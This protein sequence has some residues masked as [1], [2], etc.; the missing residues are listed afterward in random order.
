MYYACVK[1]QE[2]WSI[3]DS[4]EKYEM[5]LLR[6]LAFDLDCIL[7]HQYVLHILREVEA[8]EALAAV[9][10]N[11]LND[12]L[13][14]TLSL[15]YDPYKLAVGAIYLAGELTGDRIVSFDEWWE[16]FDCHRIE[17]DRICNALIDMYEQLASTPGPMSSSQYISTEA[18]PGPGA[19]TVT[20][21]SNGSASTATAIATANPGAAGA[22]ATN[23]VTTTTA[24][25][26]AA[27]AAAG[28]ELFPPPP[29]S[30]RQTSK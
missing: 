27:A 10:W 5:I 8:P 12:S 6:S 21:S 7:P 14:T 24:A 4:V 9:S 11:I 3:K 15:Q 20:T 16:Q 19:A 25:A 28:V 23:T 30:Y 2:Y 17:V 29:P 1:Q 22:V 18:Q 13:I 26:A